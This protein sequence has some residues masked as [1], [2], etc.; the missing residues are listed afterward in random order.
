MSHGH[1]SCKECW[2]SRWEPAGAKADG[3]PTGTSAAGEIAEDGARNH[4]GS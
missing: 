3:L 4:V 2:E 1:L